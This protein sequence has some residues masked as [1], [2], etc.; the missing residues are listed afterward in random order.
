MYRERIRCNP[1]WHGYARRD[2]VL[3]DIGGP[4]MNGLISA[5]V[6]LLLSFVF[7][8]REYQCA[9]VRW[10]VPIGDAPDPDTGMWVVEP[11]RERGTPVP[12]A[13]EST[14]LPNNPLLEGSQIAGLRC[15]GGGINIGVEEDTTALT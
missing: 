3:A 14:H 4:V 6:L 12:Q 8:E 13:V 11:E 9:L 10:F 1:N 15:G 2:T 5:R 7:S